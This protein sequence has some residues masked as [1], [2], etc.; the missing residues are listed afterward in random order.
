M[1]ICFGHHSS[2]PHRARVPWRS[3]ADGDKLDI[4][5]V[6]RDRPFPILVQIYGGGWRSALRQWWFARYLHP[7]L[8]LGG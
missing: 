1:P 2:R 7:Q 8:R 3:N 5:A 6:G 4:C